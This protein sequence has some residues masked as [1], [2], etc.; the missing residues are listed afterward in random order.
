MKL[1]MTDAVTCYPRSGDFRTGVFV[2]APTVY[3]TD[4]GTQQMTGPH[5]RFDEPDLK[6]REQYPY[7]GC[8]LQDFLNRYTDGPTPGVY[9][10]TKPVLGK[11]IQQ[12]VTIDTLDGPMTYTPGCWILENA[13]GNQWGIGPETFEKT[14]RTQ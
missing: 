14:W 1:D 7:Y 12:T 3:K 9:I 13:D 6:K 2:F 11:Q 4:W 8:E 10:K 5:M